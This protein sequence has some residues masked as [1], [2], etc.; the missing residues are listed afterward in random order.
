MWR[1]ADLTDADFREANLSGA[2]LTDAAFTGAK[3]E[4]IK[5]IDPKTIPGFKEPDA[6]EKRAS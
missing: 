3:I 4:R 5:G 6:E 2:I 1:G